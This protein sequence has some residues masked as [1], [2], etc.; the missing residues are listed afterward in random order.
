LHLTAL[1]LVESRVEAARVEAEAA[2]DY[3]EVPVSGVEPV[4]L[5]AT[6]E[7]IGTVEVEEIVVAVA[8]EVVVRSR[9][10]AHKVVLVAADEVI[11]AVTGGE[12]VAALSTY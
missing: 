7:F 12:G 2:V 8:G 6:V 1:D 10:A 9:T 3:V 4:V 5:V 11:A